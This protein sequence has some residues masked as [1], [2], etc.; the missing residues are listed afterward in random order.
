MTG[1]PGVA[2][3]SAERWGLRGRRLQ[4]STPGPLNGQHH[5]VEFHRLVEQHAIGVGD[6]AQ[7]F[8]RDVAGQDDD[9]ERRDAAFP[10]PSA[11]TS[12]PFMP[13]GRLK[14]AR[15]EVGPEIVALEQLHR[16]GRHHRRARSRWPSSLS[17]NASN[18]RNSRIVLDDQDRALARRCCAARGI[19]IPVAARPQASAAGALSAA[20]L[21]WRTR[22][23][24]H[25]AS[26]RA[27][28]G[29]A[30]CP[31]AA[32]WTGRGRGRGCARAPHCRPDGIPRKS[33]GF[34]RREC[35][36]RCPRPR[37][38]TSPRGDGSPAAPCP[39]LGVFQARSH[40]RLRSICSSRRGSL[41]IDRL[42]GTTR[43][44]DFSPA[45]DR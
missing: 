35:R 2:T 28:D 21:Q 40:S 23:H 13:L 39:L 37:C 33:P 17:E 10:A 15:I 22:S 29:R 25:G 16:L 30:D 27:R 4:S 11:T 44:R 26:A 9:R 14:S 5:V 3:V 42:Q 32:R 20:R 34:P 43:R 36:S 1:G 24:C 8:G 31:G 45:P 38:S 19:E 7:G 41:Q 18:S 6:G 12:S